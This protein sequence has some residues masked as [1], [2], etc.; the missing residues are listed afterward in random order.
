MRL[1]RLRP[2]Q[3]LPHVL[4]L[5]DQAASHHRGHAS[6]QSR[7]QSLPVSEHNHASAMSLEARSERHGETRTTALMRRTFFSQL[8]QTTHVLY[9]SSPPP[10][11]FA[12]QS[13]VSTAPYT[14][15]KGG[16][17]TGGRR[18]GERARSAGVPWYQKPEDQQHIR[19]TAAGH[20][21]VPRALVA[22]CARRWDAACWP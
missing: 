6:I 7:V 8:S 2:P 20:A 18:S 1:L 22:L 11:Q 17:R 9:S 5:L 12:P 10:L 19:K 3:Q 21:C 15:S 4:D 14:T 13:S 16:W